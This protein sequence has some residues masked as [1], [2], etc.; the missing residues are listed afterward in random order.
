MFDPDSSLALRIELCA[1]KPN[2]SVNS[3][4]S[5]QG[6]SSGT[7]GSGKRGSFKSNQLRAYSSSPDSVGHET[8]ES[9]TVL[10][11]PTG[12][13]ALD[14]LVASANA[15]ANGA[16]SSNGGGS[17]DP[18]SGHARNRSFSNP[19]SPAAA[20]VGATATLASIADFHSN[21]N[22]SQNGLFVYVCLIIF[23]SYF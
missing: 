19:M 23:V 11:S 8:P 7:I 21:S 10:N 18:G 13:S 16:S 22:D 3:P 15:A 6:N 2:T 14:A 20:T 17:G 9:P 1:V 5:S 4:P 12:S